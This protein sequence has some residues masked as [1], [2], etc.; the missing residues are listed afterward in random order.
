MDRKK[1]KKY[2]R[3]HWIKIVLICVGLV[4]LATLLVLI[5]VGLR[6]FAELESF[7]KK[8]TLAG[9]PLQ[10]F[11]SIITAFIFAS[12]YMSFHYWFLYG[13]G[14]AKMG[15]S[16][17]KAE[18][19]NVKWSD[20]VGMESAKREV[21]EVIVQDFTQPGVLHPARAAPD[22]QH[23]GDPGVDKAFAQH[24]LPDH[25]GGAEQDHFHDRMNAS[26]SALMVAA[27]VVGMPCGKP[28]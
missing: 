20:V 13:G 14:S 21:G 6:N 8:L 16:K 12:I 9:I 23:L 4:I 17:I 5:V 15:Q 7:Y 26:R 27:S 11:L 22:R 1:L 24:A 28:L 3:L 19:V 10:L 25:A 2:I 18:E